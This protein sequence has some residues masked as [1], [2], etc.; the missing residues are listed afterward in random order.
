[1]ALSAQ[2]KKKISLAVRLF[3]AFRGEQPEY[4][5][6]VRVPEHDTLLLIGECDGILYTTSRDG[7]L[8]SY[9]HEFRKSSRPL[10]CSS[11]DGKQLY[12]LGGAYSFTEAGITD[13]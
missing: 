2:K 1:M 3:K 4:V 8:E 10:L 13:R 5:E 6:T 7:R 9:L 11:F 12:L